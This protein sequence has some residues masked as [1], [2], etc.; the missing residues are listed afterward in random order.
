MVMGHYDEQIF[1]YIFTT[2]EYDMKNKKYHKRLKSI[3]QCE[4]DTEKERM[5]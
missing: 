5:E 1:D 3:S 4:N 2:D